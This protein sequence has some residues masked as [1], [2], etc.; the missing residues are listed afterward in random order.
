MLSAHDYG[1][2]ESPSFP[3]SERRVDIAHAYS[4]IE[5]KILLLLP[6]CTPYPEE[7]AR[8]STSFGL[9]KRFSA[10]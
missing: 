1:K 4:K 10:R 7:E 2:F 3:W 9:K 5:R 8:L 6:L